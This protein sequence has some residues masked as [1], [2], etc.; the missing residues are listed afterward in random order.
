MI[1]KRGRASPPVDR[2]TPKRRP[3]VPRR[4]KY[5][6]RTAD[7]HLLY[8]MSVQA[9]ENEIHF[10]DRVYRKSFGRRP[11]SLREDFCGTGLLCREWVD[12][13]K[14]REAVGLDLDP[15][16][17]DWGRRNNLEPLGKDAARMGLIEKD[18]RD[19]REPT[20]DI[21]CAFN[22]SYWV[23][24]DRADMVRYFQSARA[25]LG[26]E[27]LFVC[28]LLGGPDAQCILEERKSMRGFKYVWDQEIFNPIDHHMR[29]AIHFEFPDGTKLKRAFTYDWRLWTAAEIRDCLAEAGFSNSEIYWEGT[30]HETMEG[31]GIFTRRSRVQNEQAWIA[32]LVAFP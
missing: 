11:L 28:D 29:C 26:P 23:F 20:S 32:Y 3:T 6:A 14:K 27:G 12:S 21:I 1:S 4:R 18:V 8:Q 5:T 30:D 10:L 16:V 31:N 17:L 19:A 7:R 22:F 25:S 15:E 9:P 24:K 2:P 13:H